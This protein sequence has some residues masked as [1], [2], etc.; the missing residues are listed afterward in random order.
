LVGRGKDNDAKIREIGS[1]LEKRK[2][3]RADT[4]ENSKGKE[5]RRESFWLIWVELGGNDGGEE[6]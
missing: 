2:P 3:T 5:K 6:Q 4:K 1:G